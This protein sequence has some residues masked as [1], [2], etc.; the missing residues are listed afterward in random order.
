MGININKELDNLQ[1]ENIIWLI[2]LF[3]I[4]ASFISNYFAERYLYTMDPQIKKIFR[5]INIFVLSI[6]LLI[7]LYY[8]YVA[9]ESIKEDDH[10]LWKYLIL[11]ASILVLIGGIIYLY[12]EIYKN[13]NPEISLV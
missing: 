4:G 6:A 9:Y 8:A 13:A 7:Y 3:I 11:I 5:N 1:I 2:Y 12:V 10:S